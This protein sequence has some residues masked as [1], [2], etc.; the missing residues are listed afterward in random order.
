MSPQQTAD[1]L[2]VLPRLV[3]RDLAEMGFTGDRRAVMAD[4]SAA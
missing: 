3:Q 1:A 4:A 2:R